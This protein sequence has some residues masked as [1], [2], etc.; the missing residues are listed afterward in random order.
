MADVA[1]QP[2]N[3]PGFPTSW[4]G[5]AADYEVDPDVGL[6]PE[7][8]LDI[9]SLAMTI[10]GLDLFEAQPETPPSKHESAI[11]R[12]LADLQADRLTPLEALNILSQLVDRAS[13]ARER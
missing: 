12:E 4:A 3:P 6:Q 9:P 10:T 2:A 7:H 13:A 8:L 11:E 1:G 5:I